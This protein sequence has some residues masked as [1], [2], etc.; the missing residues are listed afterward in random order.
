MV[1][2]SPGSDEHLVCIC[3]VVAYLDPQHDCSTERIIMKTLCISQT[4]FINDTL[5]ILVD[6]PLQ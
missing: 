4:V 6:D 3:R 5:A 2:R 1:A